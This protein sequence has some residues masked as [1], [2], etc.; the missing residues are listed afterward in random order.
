MTTRTLRVGIVGLHVGRSWASNA[1]LPALR[2]MPEAFA[3]AGV[4]NASRAS[5]EAAAAAANLPR[6][7]ASVAE[8]V[9]SPDVDLVAI[10][11]KVPHHLELASA[12]LDA[13]KHVYCEWPLGNGSREAEALAA[14]ARRKGVVAVAGTQARMAP[15]VRFAATLVAEGYVGDVLSSSVSGW[16]RGWGAVIDT[17]VNR[18]VLDRDNGATML[19][20]PIGHTLAAI[21]DVLGA[22]SEVSAVMAN[23][24]P[25]IKELD[26]GTVLPKTSHDQI[27][28]SAVLAGGAPLSLHYRGGLPRSGPGLVWDIHGTR[29]DLRITGP[30]GHAQLVPL[31]LEGARGDEPALHALEVPAPYHEGFAGHTATTGNVARVYAR[32]AADIRGGSR[33][34]PSFDDAVALHH[35]LDAIEASAASGTRVSPVNEPR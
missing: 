4:A 1:H 2:A 7:F 13:G 33:T 29:G 12:A 27:L 22:V 19:S 6:A 23:R 18:Y 21:C 3:I 10:T 35:V 25:E 30:F 8:L 34:A 24:I 9:A 15:E 32:M 26:S 20:I 14:L 31:A 5:S 11:V 16:G 17:A 28:V